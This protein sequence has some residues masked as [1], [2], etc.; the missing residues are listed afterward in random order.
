MIIKSNTNEFNEVLPGIQ[1]SNLTFG[2]KTHLTKVILKKGSIIPE[3]NHPNEQTGY[4]ISG[5]LRFFSGDKEF[6]ADTGDCWTILGNTDH[7]A[8]ALE[9]TVVLECF[10]PVREDYLKLE[11]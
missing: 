1:L 10:S 8:E 4:L 5:K 3:H 9:D 7:G 2:E 11:N 6:I